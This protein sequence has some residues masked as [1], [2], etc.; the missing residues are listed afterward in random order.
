MSAGVAGICPFKSWTAGL[1]GAKIIKNWEKHGLA[2]W[3]IE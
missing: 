2:W 3:C 1:A